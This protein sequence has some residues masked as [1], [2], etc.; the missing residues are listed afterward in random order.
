MKHSN[1]QNLLLVALFILAVVGY[2]LWFSGE[3]VTD[4]GSVIT[5][6]DTSLVELAAELS[7]VSFDPTLFNSG[8]YQNLKDFSIELPNQPTK[9]SNPFNVIGRD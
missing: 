5:Q 7:Q 2:N 1:R 4:D 8:A 3:E 9:R 6:A